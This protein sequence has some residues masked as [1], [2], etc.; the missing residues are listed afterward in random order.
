MNAIKQIAELGQSIW[1][2]NLSRY[3]RYNDDKYF[4]AIGPGTASPTNAFLLN[5]GGTNFRPGNTDFGLHALRAT[6]NFRF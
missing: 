6:L 3:S 2:D 5:G 1:L 4:V